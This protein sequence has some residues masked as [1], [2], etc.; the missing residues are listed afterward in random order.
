MAQSVVNILVVNSK[1]GCGKT[2]V[3]TNLAAAYANDGKKV[4]L[5]DCDRQ[6][7][8]QHW[9]GARGLDLPSIDLYQRPEPAQIDQG[10]MGQYDTCV[11]DSG[12]GISTQPS[13]HAEFE[14][15]L[16]LSDVIVVPMLSSAWDIQAGEH[17]VTQLMT[18]RVWR[19]APKPIAVVGN[20]VNGNLAGQQKLQ[21]F[22]SCLDVPAVSQFRES[23]VY[24]EAGDSGQGIVEMKRNRAARKEFKAWHTLLGW[25]DEQTLT[26]TS[27]RLPA[28]PLA[29]SR[30]DRRTNDDATT[31]RA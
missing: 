24:A 7:S 2:T 10:A 20:R 19:A 16:R 18:Q 6:A 31:E 14:S 17:F 4:A 30:A 29:A 1:G 3:A 28:M 5:F 9:V 12:P 25:I 22:L 27:K 26:A 13:L 11:F 21:H 15:L 8:A 23:P